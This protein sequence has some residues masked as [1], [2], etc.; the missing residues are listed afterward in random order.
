[1]RILEAEP[2]ALNNGQLHELIGSLRRDERDFQKRVTDQVTALERAG[3]MHGSDPV[4]QSLFFLLRKF[5]KQLRRAE[6]ELARRDSDVRAWPR[7]RPHS[8][9]VE[10]TH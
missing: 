3:R 1:M 5:S 2:K 6:E 9:A 10:L 4:Y 7:G 8:E